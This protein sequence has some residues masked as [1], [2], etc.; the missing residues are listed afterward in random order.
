MNAKTTY[1]T[2]SIPY[3]N[4]RPHL[5]F[6]LELCISDALARL[7]RERGLAVRFV[8]GTDDNSLKNVLAAERAGV[9]T[10]HFVAEHAAAFEALGRELGVSVDAFLRT[11]ASPNHAP[12]VRALWS[13]CAASGDLYRRTYRGL[14]CV[15]CERF[16]EPEELAGDRCP[17]HDSVLEAVSEENWF[18]RLS[19]YRARILEAVESGRLRIH[20]EGAREEA[21]SFLR[22]EVRD[23]SISRSAARARGWGVPVPGDSSQVIWVWFDALAS[24]LSA[25]GFAGDAPADFERFWKGSGERVHVL[26]K[27]I[28]R[29]HAVFWPAFLASA[30]IPWPTD[31]LVH[32]HLTVG[33]RKISKSGQSVDPIPLLRRFGPDALRF[34]LLKHVR[35][36]R[37]ADFRPDRFAQAY[38]AELANGLGNLE[39]RLFGLVERTTGG[40]VPEGGA[41]IPEDGELREAALSLRARVDEAAARF[42]VDEAIGAVFDLVEAANR[43]LAR[44][45]PWALLK[46]GRREE[47]GASLR[48]SLEALRIV[49]GELRPFLPSTASALEGRLGVSARGAG[50]AAPTW[51]ALAAGARL[52]RGAPLFPRVDIEALEALGEAESGSP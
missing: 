14:Y 7:R 23:L 34:F 33:G 20:G 27:G 6:A 5:G 32:G 13:A 42:A 10:H 52:E 4:A 37:D 49:A 43:H 19:K 25:L 45:A 1:V 24:Y 31:L 22:G 12:A 21:L 18:F 50:A 16:F 26:G 35:T 30:G 38:N 47:A 39:S 9:P 41:Q 51:N 8:S 15:G 48:A 2:T 17:E 44:T 40:F 3:V 28:S 11:S 46:A 36:T 29:F